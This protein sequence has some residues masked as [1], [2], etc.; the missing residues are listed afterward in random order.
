MWTRPASLR[1]VRVADGVV[2]VAIVILPSLHKT[3]PSLLAAKAVRLARAS[4]VNVSNAFLHMYLSPPFLVGVAETGTR[5]LTPAATFA[6][7]VGPAKLPP[8]LNFYEQLGCD[9]ARIGEQNR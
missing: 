8:G 7:A 9:N 6:T 5:N 3:V 1:S 4:T 2:F